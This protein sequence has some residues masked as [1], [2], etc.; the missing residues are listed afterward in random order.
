MVVAENEYAK[1]HCVSDFDCIVQSR[2]ARSYRNSR[3]ISIVQTVAPI[4]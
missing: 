1:F 2:I 4:R 3:K